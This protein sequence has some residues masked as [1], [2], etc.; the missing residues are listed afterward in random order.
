M[1]SA[2]VTQACQWKGKDQRAKLFHA[3]CLRQMWHDE[4]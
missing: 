4:V 2:Q 3:L 1:Q